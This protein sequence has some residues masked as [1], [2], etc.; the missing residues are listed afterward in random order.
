MPQ[1][2]NREALTNC[3]LGGALGDSIGLPAEG[4]PAKRIA[5]LWPG[6]LQHRFFFGFGMV[7]DDTEHAVMTALSLAKHG[8]D[9]ERF[10]RDLARR[11]RW[12]FAGMPAGI[13]LGTARS[14]LNGLAQHE[15]VKV[16]EMAGL[17]ALGRE[18]MNIFCCLTAKCTLIGNHINIGA[19]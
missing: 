1:F 4:I 14:I 10:A 9:P 13:G 18:I 7:S 3:L 19:T 15:C 11:L 8:A 2:V 5:R 17:V 12:W 6:P 16:D